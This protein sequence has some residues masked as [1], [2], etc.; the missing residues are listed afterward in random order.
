MISPFAIYYYSVYG[1]GLDF[2]NTTPATSWL[3]AF[4]LP[5]FAKTSSFILN[6]YK[7]AGWTL[8][9][10]GFL[11]FCIGAGQIYYSKF[12][13]KQAVTGGIYNFIRHPQYLSLS[14]CSFG[15]LLVWP[16]YLVLIMFISML[17]AY[18]F[19]AR[20]EER[21]CEVKFGGPYVEYKNRTYMFLPLPFKQLP[22][23]PESGMKRYLA[24]LALYLIVVASSIGVAQVLKNH[25]IRNLYAIY[26]GSSATISLEK[27]DKNRFER[28][29][30]IALK[31]DKVQKR[32]FAANSSPTAKFLNYV[33]PAEWFIPDIPMKDVQGIGEHYTPDAYDTDRYKILFMHAVLQPDAASSDGIEL[34]IHTVR[35]IPIIE[36]EVSLEQNKVI[37]RENPPATVVWGD[38][39]TPLF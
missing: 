23:L 6:T 38:I 3:T 32:L 19:L 22:R 39:P 18:Y 12:T 37:H 29:M 36:V 27:I 26:S 11:A 20:A 10:G 35:R 13:K 28:I 21:E 5:H 24:V 2:L 16:R 15:L 14:V 4:F 1:K 30:E 34:I 8:A 9:I 25:S 17:F 31:D 7:D 33:L